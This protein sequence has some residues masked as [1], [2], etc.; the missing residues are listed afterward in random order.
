MS[1]SLISGFFHVKLRDWDPRSRPFRNQG[2]STRLCG[3]LCVLA[4]GPLPSAPAKFHVSERGWRAALDQKY[5]QNAAMDFFIHTITNDSCESCWPLYAL[6]T[7]VVNPL[8]R[9]PS[10]AGRVWIMMEQKENTV[11]RNTIRFCTFPLVLAHA[12]EKFFHCRGAHG[13]GKY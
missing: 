11:L 9:A 4:L 12:V 5:E 7:P 1:S 10:G 8:G 3:L 6:Q 2:S 13:T